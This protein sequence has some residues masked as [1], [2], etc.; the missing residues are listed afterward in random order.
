MTLAP[1]I[2]T[3]KTRSGDFDAKDVEGSRRLLEAARKKNP[4]LAPPEVMLAQLL[5]HS[6]QL[7]AARNEIERAVRRW[8]NDPE[9]YV[10]LAEAAVSDGRIAE[11]GLLF[12]KAAAVA[13]A[14]SENPKRKVTLLNRVYTGAAA[15]DESREQ[16]SAARDDLTQLAKLEPSNAN[17][18][19]RLGRVQFK[20]GDVHAAYKELQTVIKIDPK[21]PPPEMVLANLYKQAGDS[22]ASDKMIAAAIKHGPDDFGTQLE[23]A[24]WML[25]NNK[26]EEAKTYADEALEAGSA[27]RRSP[28]GGAVSSPACSRTTNP[29]SVTWKR[30]I[31][32][33]RSMLR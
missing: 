23:L 24:K 20:L 27:K 7:P 18:H 15:I 3:S 19:L 28:A 31:C 2:R 4:K 9:A 8:P 16:W 12:P 33:C 13:E 11:A 5:V 21:Q 1:S 26:I 32:N 25:A 22:S 29:P 10:I 14:F 17:V 6:N 30:P